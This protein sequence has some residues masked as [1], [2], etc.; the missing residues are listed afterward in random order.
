[1]DSA[2]RAVGLR[3][4]VGEGGSMID[5]A[6]VFLSSQEP[7]LFSQAGSDGG[8]SMRRG[9]PVRL[10]ARL[11]APQQPLEGLR[12]TPRRCY[13]GIERA[14]SVSPFLY[15]GA[16]LEA[17]ALPE[18]DA[19]LRRVPASLHRSGRTSLARCASLIG[20]VR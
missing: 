14:R 16:E 10:M 7:Q 1:M 17:R 9:L 11:I 3:G 5:R 19:R 8:L 18:R 6:T 20:A 12:G 15:R 2:G 4:A 13:E